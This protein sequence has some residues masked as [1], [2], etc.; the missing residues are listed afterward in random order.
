MDDTWLCAVECVVEWRSRAPAGG[1]RR[2]AR[3]QHG[4]TGRTGN[5]QPTRW[6]CQYTGVT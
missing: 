4:A 6:S 2:A 5:A 1:A 3:V